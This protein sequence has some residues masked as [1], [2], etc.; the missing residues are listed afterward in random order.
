[1][2]MRRTHVAGVACGLAAL[3]I[4]LVPALVWAEE[5]LGTIKSVD[6]PGKRFL[7]TQDSDHQDVAVRVT[8]R[9]ELPRQGGT[10]KDLVALKPGTRVRVANAFVAS[11]VTVEPEKAV[12]TT[13]G[14]SVLAEFWYNFR[15]NL[16]KPLLLFFYLGFV[17][18][19]LQVQF[20]FPYVVYQALTIYLLI[21][22]GWHGGEELAGLKPELLSHVLGFMC[23]GFGL[24]FVIGLIAFGILRLATNL[25][26]VDQATVA[27]YY[28][29]DSAGTFVTCLGVLA[30]THIAY[31]AYMPVMLAVMEIPGCLVALYLI[32]RLRHHGMDALGNMPHE[33]GYDPKAQRPKPAST[34]GDAHGHGHSAVEEEK[35]IALE[36]MEHGP[37]PHFSPYSFGDRLLAD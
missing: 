34:G 20:E 30:S 35:E 3:V 19:L 27:G 16:F 12:G 1:M 26:E 28:G 25:R 37:N 36:K 11:K 5:V 31:D 18:V 2:R 33:P 23:T 7:L 14:R 32:S 13:S 6:V 22:I 24:N 8:E 10:I 9:T 15:H 4:A 17:I 21:A 29:S